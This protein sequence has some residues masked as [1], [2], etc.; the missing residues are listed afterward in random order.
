MVSVMI[1][2]FS[3]TC[4]TRQY[5]F[6]L[7][8]KNFHVESM[9]NWLGNQCALLCLVVKSL[10]VYKLAACSFITTYCSWGQVVIVDEDYNVF[11]TL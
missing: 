1:S 3:I 9:T 7:Y 10:R 8:I 2:K 4:W 5:Q 6:R 11:E